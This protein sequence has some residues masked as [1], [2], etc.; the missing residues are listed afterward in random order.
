MLLKWN[1][2]LLWREI[3]SPSF[4]VIFTESS[5]LT[6]VFLIRHRSIFQISTFV[7]VPSGY[8][9]P[10]SGS[11][12]RN[13]LPYIITADSFQKQCGPPVLDERRMLICAAI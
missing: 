5:G 1:F 6:K 12:E 10:V 13:S 7:A 2:K 11:S 8:K 9:Q 3:Q 4:C